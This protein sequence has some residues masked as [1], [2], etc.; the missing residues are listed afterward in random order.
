MKKSF[1]FILYILIIFLLLSLILPIKFINGEVYNQRRIYEILF[2]TITCIVTILSKDKIDLVLKTFLSFRTSIKLAFLIIILLNILSSLINAKSI[3]TALMGASLFNLLFIATILLANHFKQNR[4][5]YIYMIFT[6]YLCIFLY[7]FELF[8]NYFFITSDP[9]TST[10][11]KLL[12]IQHAHSGLFFENPRFLDNVLSCIWCVSL[13][14]L[15][16]DSNK[17]LKF[18]SFVATTLIFY[19]AIIGNGRTILLEIITILTFSLF[20]YKRHALK[21][22]VYSLI[23]FTLAFIMFKCIF[24]VINLNIDSFVDR[25]PISS[26]GRITLWQ[27]CF[28]EGLNKP[29]LGVG[30]LNVP[31]YFD[32]ITTSGSAYPHSL[33]FTLI[34]ENGFIVTFLVFYII[35]YSLYNLFKEQKNHYNPISSLFFMSL[36]SIL[37]DSMVSNFFIQPQSQILAIGILAFCMGFKSHKNKEPTRF[38]RLFLRLFLIA[39]LI[40]LISVAC[41]Q[42]YLMTNQAIIDDAKLNRLAP[43][44][45]LQGWL[46]TGY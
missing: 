10:Q 45:W 7:S 12:L 32:P 8:T 21:F 13:I 43:S 2:L 23:C 31:F 25:N 33:F 5:S 41:Y 40:T 4:N 39:C 27:I 29:I 38:Q 44:F 22:I 3:S 42:L 26:S 30:I 24:Y 14:P 36:V 20:L 34:A 16:I 11:I 19:I 28:D 9:Y 18:L 37:I 1:I 17:K 35:V 46:Q 15:L 6:F